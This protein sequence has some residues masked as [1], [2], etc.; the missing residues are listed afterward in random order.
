M[1]SLAAGSLIS[2]THVVSRSRLISFPRTVGTA[3]AFT[4]GAASGYR[5]VTFGTSFPVGGRPAIAPSFAILISTPFTFAVLVIAPFSTN[6]AHALTK[7]AKPLAQL[8]AHGVDF[9]LIQLTVTIRIEC[10]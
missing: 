6:V 9:S 2:R 7:L 10:P 4:K 8:L 3:T 5:A 1:T